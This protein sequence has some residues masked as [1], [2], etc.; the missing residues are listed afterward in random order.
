MIGSWAVDATGIQSIALRDL[1]KTA[2]QQVLDRAKDMLAAGRGEA[3]VAQW[4]VQSR[5]QLKVAIRQ[6]GPDILRLI[7]E[8]RSEAQPIVR[9]R[10]GRPTD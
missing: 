9:G 3:E 10:G 7:N 6:Q 2:A 5:K 8:A 1:Y 4:G